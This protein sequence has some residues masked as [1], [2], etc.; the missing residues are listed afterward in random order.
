MK[1][2]LSFPIEHDGRR[3]TNVTI[4]RPRV[5]D[6][7]E[8]QRK[9]GDAAGME[10]TMVALLTGLPPEAISEMDMKDYNAIQAALR[11]MTGN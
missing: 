5:G 4:R 8:M 7:L 11:T 3:I 1:I 2:D 9:G 10:L 6:M